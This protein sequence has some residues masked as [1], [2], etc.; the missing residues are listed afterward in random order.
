MASAVTLSWR[1]ILLRLPMLAGL[2]SGDSTNLMAMPGQANR[3]LTS[4]E[5]ARWKY[6]ACFVVVLRIERRETNIG[7]TA[8]SVPEAVRAMKHLCLY[9]QEPTSQP[10]LVMKLYSGS[11]PRPETSEKLSRCRMRFFKLLFDMLHRT[12]VKHQTTQWLSCLRT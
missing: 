5:T 7:Y 3:L 4:S 1:R 6:A 8:L 9:L 12:G 10:K 11:L 2:K